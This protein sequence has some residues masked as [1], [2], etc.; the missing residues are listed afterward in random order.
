MT[1]TPNPN[2]VDTDSLTGEMHPIRRVV[3]AL[4]SNLGE[5]LA[6]LQGAVDAL[7]DT[8]D[9]FVTGVSPVYETDPVDSPEE[10]GPFLNAVVLADT[11]LPAARLMERALAIE[12]AFER[13]RSDIRNAPRTLDVDLIVVGD[14]RSN[15]DFLRLPHPRAHQRAFVLKPWH[16]LEPDAVFPERGPIADLL[17]ETDAS[18]V[19]KREDLAL[20]AE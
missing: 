15:E 8:P 13:E 6:S 9:F 18:G 7:R 2:I 10:A 5:R 14:R 17:G 4:G 12:D 19:R 1:E 20:E 3:V 16:D 11:T